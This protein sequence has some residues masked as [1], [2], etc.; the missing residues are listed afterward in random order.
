MASEIAPVPS[1]A[2]RQSKLEIH[3]APVRLLRFAGLALSTSFVL[4]L[5]L[6]RLWPFELFS[7]YRAQFATALLLSALILM[8]TKC[9]RLAIVNALLGLIAVW[10]VLWFYI[11]ARQPPAG[12]QYLRLMS[13]NVLNSNVSKEPFERLVREIDPDVLVIVEYTHVWDGK[14]SGTKAHFPY[15]AECPRPHGF[16]IA[17]YSKWPLENV[18]EFN[19][20][21]DVDAPSILCEMILGTRRIQIAAVHTLSPLSRNRFEIRNSQLRNLAIRVK[22]NPNP[23]IVAGD[24]NATTWSP[25]IRDFLQ[26]TGLRDS[27]AGF[28]PQPSW[29]TFFKPMLIPIDHAFVSAEFR[30]LRCWVER[31]IGSDHF[32]IVVDMSLNEPIAPPASSQADVAAGQ[33]Q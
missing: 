20:G 18:E 6:A 27:R 13:A 8:A 5:I 22:S 7:H 2:H 1:E 30:V 9:K 19:Y 26:S 15:R 11:P 3:H 10:P 32:P 4:T 12:N 21:S 16:G 28:G 33:G 29:P 17:V 31:D 14:L 24:F 25:F 23:H